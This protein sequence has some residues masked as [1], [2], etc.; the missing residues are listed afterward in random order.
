MHISPS[1]TAILLGLYG[2]DN[3]EIG[4]NNKEHVKIKD[5]R[6]LCI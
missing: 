3:I 1:L 6:P 2:L 4:T 5:K